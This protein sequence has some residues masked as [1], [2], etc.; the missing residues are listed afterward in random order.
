MPLHPELPTAFHKGLFDGVVPEGVTAQAPSE[1]EQ[2]FAVYRNNVAHSLIQALRSRFPT[3][4][5]L[6]GAEFFAA[7]ARVFAAHHP[8]AGPVLAEWGDGF[9]DFLTRFPPVAKLPYLPDV[10]RVEF[11]RGRAYHAADCAPI[12]PETLQSIIAQ[13]AETR[14]T[15]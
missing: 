13:I 9:A 10:A 14:L 6:V 4:E 3:I 5:A 15:V 12:D 7:M 1:T 2:R 11:A 8:P